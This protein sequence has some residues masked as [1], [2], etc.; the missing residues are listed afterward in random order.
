M[1]TRD[2]QVAASTDDARNAAGNGMFNATVTTQH[3]GRNAG[4]DYWAGL[5]FANVAVPQG[6]VIQSASLDL[7]SS[8]VAAGSSVPV[9]FHGEKSAN[10]AAFSNTT[11]G[12]PE[13]R[14]RTAAT[15]TKTFDPAQ[16][17]PETGFGVDV[18]DVTALVQEIVDQPAF[19][20]GNAIALIGHDN[21]AA[22]NNFI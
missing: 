8:G 22:N 17:N 7:Y 12:K 14:T 10:P 18:V 11:A 5:R 13:G 3:L 4:I 6:A 1:P 9:V 19:A 21:G 15:V 2:L 20:S 16:W